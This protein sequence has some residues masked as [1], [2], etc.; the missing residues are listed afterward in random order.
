MYLFFM[1]LEDKWKEA[2]EDLKDFNKSMEVIRKYPIKTFVQV[3]CDDY[4]I[5]G[6][7]I[8]PSQ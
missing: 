6:P 1:N 2:E 3:K 8:Y 4:D 5:E 7:V